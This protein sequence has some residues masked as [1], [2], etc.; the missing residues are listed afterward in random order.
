MYLWKMGTERDFALGYGCTIQCSDD[1][2]LIFTLETCVVLW[3]NI[4]SID[5]IKIKW[6]NKN[7]M[8]FYYNAVSWKWIWGKG[9]FVC[10]SI[11]V[12]SVAEME[13][14]K[15]GRVGWWVRKKR[16]EKR[17]KLTDQN[18]SI[19]F[20]SMFTFILK[21]IFLIQSFRSLGNFNDESVFVPFVMGLIICQWSL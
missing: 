14:R 18:I 15:E 7:K 2:L 8:E 13:E 20:L 12:S 19:Y 21:F 4:T 1:V 10:R 16:K 5:S 3:T 6:E 9:N 17:M 11:H